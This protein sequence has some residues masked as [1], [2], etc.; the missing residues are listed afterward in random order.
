M[1][2]LIIIIIFSLIQA[3]FLIGAI[4]SYIYEDKLSIYF[5]NY[6]EKEIEVFIMIFWCPLVL[7]LPF[8]KVSHYLKKY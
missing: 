6:D 2:F 8:D 7:G 4:I 1:I 3:Y 5:R